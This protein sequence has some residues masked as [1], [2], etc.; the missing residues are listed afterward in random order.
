MSDSI[1]RYEEMQEEHMLNTETA[2]EN[3]IGKKKEFERITKD[4]I[5]YLYKYATPHT[6]IIITH[7]FEL[8]D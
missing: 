6:T 8:R 5:D 3:Q 4:F 2:A 1:T 7:K